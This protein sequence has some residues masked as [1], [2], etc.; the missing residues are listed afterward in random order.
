MF[1]LPAS[2]TNNVNM[3]S[4]PTDS[5]RQ[6]DCYFCKQCGARLVHKTEGNK[7]ISVKGGCLVG[8]SKEMVTGKGAVHIW[9]KSAVVDVPEGMERWE[10][11]PDEKP[12]SV[13]LE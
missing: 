7:T 12:G 8:L 11:E 9:T 10:K 4:R 2:T 5:G 3:Y 13:P 6:L 1:D